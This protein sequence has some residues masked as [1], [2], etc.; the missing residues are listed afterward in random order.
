MSIVYPV[1]YH[2]DSYRESYFRL[3][4]KPIKELEGCKNKQRALLKKIFEPLICI[5][6][7][8]RCFPALSLQACRN[9]WYKAYNNRLKQKLQYKP[10]AGKIK[11]LRKMS[12]CK[13]SPYHVLSGAPPCIPAD[14]SYLVI[15][16]AKISVQQLNWTYFINCEKYFLPFTKC[17]QTT[18]PL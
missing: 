1:L 17:S 7:C 16:G 15:C 9:A 11:M 2:P 8:I 18:L 5:W 13:K 10:P 3:L 12:N 4:L 6:E 14:N